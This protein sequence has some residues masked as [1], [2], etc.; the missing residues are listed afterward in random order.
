VRTAWILLV[1]VLLVA[2]SLRA[3]DEFEFAVP[4]EG[5]ITLGVFDGSG[6]LVRL[7]HRLAKEEDFLVGWK[8]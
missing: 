2:S 8:K 4:D 1:V 5:R 7:L 6:K 3:S